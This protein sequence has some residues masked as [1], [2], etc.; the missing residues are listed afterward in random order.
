MCVFKNTQNYATFFFLELGLP[1]IT[2]G[3]PNTTIRLMLR[4][5]VETEGMTVAI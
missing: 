2:Q 5:G 3:N 1:E 4:L